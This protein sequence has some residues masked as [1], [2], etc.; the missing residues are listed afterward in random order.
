MIQP[1]APDIPQAFLGTWQYVMRRHSASRSLRPTETPSV[2]MASLRRVTFWAFGTELACALF[3]ILVAKYSLPVPS[4]V[5][6][7]FRWGF[8]VSVIVMML[9]ALTTTIAMFIEAARKLTWNPSDYWLDF[10]GKESQADH[11]LFESLRQLTLNELRFGLGLLQ[12]RADRFK[13]R[14]RDLGLFLSIPVFIA[15][16]QSLATVPEPSIQ[17][18]LQ[19]IFGYLHQVGSSSDYLSWGVFA[20]CLTLIL[21]IYFRQPGDVLREQITLVRAGIQ[22]RAIDAE[23]A[24]T[25]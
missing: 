19:V 13:T 11:A 6:D 15:G 22:C 12:N 17:R 3:L 7:A 1:F 16:S 14:W 18:Y 24:T 20:G 21:V 4:C 9:T 2:F 5:T 25:L 8:L 10:S 23:T